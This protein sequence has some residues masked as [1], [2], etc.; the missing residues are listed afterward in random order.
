MD[1]HGA[2]VYIYT[3]ADTDKQTGQ[4]VN[5]NDYGFY[6]FDG[7]SNQWMKMGS[8]GDDLQN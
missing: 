7:Y 8:A 3:P 1:Q 4:T 6:Y 5:I 2:I